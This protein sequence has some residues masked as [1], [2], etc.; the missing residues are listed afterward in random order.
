VRPINRVLLHDA[1]YEGA[2]AEFLSAHEHYRH[3]RNKEALTDAL[4]SFE[5]VMKSICTKRRDPS[6]SET[7]PYYRL[8]QFALGIRF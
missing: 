4:K 5:S 7:S 8:K 3:A 6:A 2:E 1:A